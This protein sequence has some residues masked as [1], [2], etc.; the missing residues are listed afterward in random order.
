MKRSSLQT[1]A[2]PLVLRKD[3]IMTNLQVDE[4]IAWGADSLLLI[5]KSLGTKLAPLYAHCIA[6]NI[7]PL[8]EVA[9]ELEMDAAVACGAKLIGVN[10]RFVLFA[11]LWPPHTNEPASLQQ[12]RHVYNEHRLF[13]APFGIFE[14]E[15]F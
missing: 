15:A 13:G 11:V 12:S 1:A 8:V 10:N 6:K 14:A 3:F 2:A 9:S 5:V 4:S 7:E